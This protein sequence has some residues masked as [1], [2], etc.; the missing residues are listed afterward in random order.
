MLKQKLMDFSG[1]FH[2]LSQVLEKQSREKRN[3]TP[4]DMHGLTGGLS[5]DMYGK[6]SD[7]EYYSEQTARK[8]M[9]LENKLAQN[10]CLL[11][12]QMEQVGDL[13]RN[14]AEDLDKYQPV[15]VEMEGIIKKEMGRMQVSVR[16]PVVYQNRDG[17]WEIYFQATTIKGRLVTAREAAETLSRLMGCPIIP[18]EEC[19]HVIGRREI[20]MVFVENTPFYALTGVARMA[21]EGESVSGDTFSCLSLPKG[22][23][24]LAL[25]D[26][27]G[28]GEDAL[29]ESSNVIE[30]L[31]QMTEAGF[32]KIS[33]LK[34]INSLYMPESEKSGFATADVVVINLYQGD[35]HF[36]KNGAAATWIWRRNCLERIEGQ[37]LPVGVWQEAAPYLNKTHISSGDYVIMV[38][39][40]VVDAFR[41]REKD[42]EEIFW[43]KKIINPQEL[44]EYILEEAVKQWGGVAEDDM[45]VVVAG[46][47]ERDNSSEM[48][49]KGMGR[50][51]GY[52]EAG[53]LSQG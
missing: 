6:Y 15:S 40:G 46:I 13:L 2:K 10:R 3:M 38:T 8:I 28:S 4:W 44:A 24:L 7:E 19:H 35:C 31:E 27:M 50:K 20:P 39:D 14:L 11:A 53:I 21:K 51:Q 48:R 9:S 12:S 30:L 25:S 42:L 26:G 33:A 43:N 5:Q 41:G 45:S 23:L 49:Y 47:W 22:E 32:S 18:S 37:A 34:L 1:S 29:E 17:H 36:I 52:H 16:N